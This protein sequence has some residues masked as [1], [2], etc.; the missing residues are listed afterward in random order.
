MD[1]ASQLNDPT[2][3][4]GVQYQENSNLTCRI[5]HPD[6]RGLSASLT[7]MSMVH[8]NHETF[9]YS[10]N[11][12]QQQVDGTP[13]ACKT[14][15][16]AGYT[17]FDQII[18]FT[19]HQQINPDFMFSHQ[20]AYGQDCLACHDGIDT[21]GSD[22][23]HDTTAF[24][25]VGKHNQLACVDCHPTARSIADL[26]A[27]P[28]DC[29]SCH[30]GDDAHQGEFGAGCATCHTPDGWLPASFDH[31]LTRFPLTGAHTQIEC[32]QCHNTLTFAGLSLV[33]SSCH[34]DPAIHAGLFA[35]MTCDQCHS[36]S[37]W[38]PASFNLN[39]PA[40]C[41]DEN[42]INHEEASCR[43][44]HPDSLSTATCLKCHSSNNPDDDHGDDD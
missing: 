38:A 17:A 7:D 5:C 29:Y 8:I 27:T 18:C 26:K 34:T 44:C 36:T 28:Q 25:L 33:C 6:H 11:A 14:C 15:H 13:F 40:Q 21:Y 9:G 31:A 22:F 12:H 3:L 19:C 30:A 4:H 37:A 1:V 32:T 20:Q 23:D 42:C 10:L 16:V 39:H 35:G 24:Q 43:D 2:S 41:D